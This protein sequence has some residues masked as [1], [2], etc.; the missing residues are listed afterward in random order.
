MGRQRN[1]QES[2]CDGPFQRGHGEP[3]WI[4]RVGSHGRLRIPD[5]IAKA[6]G[7][8]DGDRLD[9]EVLDLAEGGWAMNVINRDALSR[10]PGGTG[11]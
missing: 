5:E 3:Y 8:R 11:D 6:Q 4:C 9:I 1:R 10:T 7:W 2:T